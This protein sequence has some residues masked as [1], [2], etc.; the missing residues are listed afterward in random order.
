MINIIGQVVG[1]GIE[2]IGVGLMFGAKA[3]ATVTRSVFFVGGKNVDMVDTLRDMG[4]VREIDEDAGLIEVRTSVTMPRV[5]ALPSA[6]DRDTVVRVFGLIRQAL[7][8]GESA[9]RENIL[10]IEEIVIVDRQ[11]EVMAKAIEKYLHKNE[12]HGLKKEFGCRASA[13]VNAAA[14]YMKYHHSGDEKHRGE[15]ERALEDAMFAS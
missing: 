7:E 12:D 15:A 3:V 6:I 4:T 2:F 14:L 5:E 11:A 13:F 1:K 9:Y 8:Y 10:P